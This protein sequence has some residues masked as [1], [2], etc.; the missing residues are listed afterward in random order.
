MDSPSLFGSSPSDSSI[1]IPF[2][3]EISIPSLPNVSWSFR[4]PFNL[5]SP[6]LNS[7]VSLQFHVSSFGRVDPNRQNGIFELL[8]EPG[9]LGPVNFCILPP[10]SSSA[11]SASTGPGPAPG[12]L[13]T[14]VAPAAPPSLDPPCF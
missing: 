7:F 9:V 11:W 13:S 1:S 6:L 8:V 10:D 14:L 3:V 12:S 5:V 4:G 2:G